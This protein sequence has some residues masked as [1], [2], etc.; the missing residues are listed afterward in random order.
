MGKHHTHPV[1]DAGDFDIYLLAQSWSPQFCCTNR[2]DRC[3]T[4][5]WAFSA[6]HL[7]LHGLWPAYSTPRGGER[8]PVDCRVKARLVS[9]QLPRDYVDLAPSFTKWNA[10]L[11]RAEVGALAKHEWQKHGTCS[12]LGPQ[13]YFEEALRAMQALPGERGTPRSLVKAV[14]GS[15]PT[16]TVRSEYGKAVA[17]RADKHCRLA[18]VTSCW[19]KAPD[20]RVG[21]QIDC[22]PAVMQG[23]DS[24][25]KCR[26][27]YVT[28]LGQCLAADQEKQ[29]GGGRR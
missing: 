11:H 23:R 8:S 7:S 12:G 18:E 20:G 27:L 21:A 4:V 17:L 22:P 24:A 9:E 2:A 3:S 5:G 15:V 10:E 26:S 14:G 19:S 28:A 16:Q 25:A 1:G 13:Q 6:K 29:K